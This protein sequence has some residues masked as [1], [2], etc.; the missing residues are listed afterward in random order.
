MFLITLG[1]RGIGDTA[2]LHIREQAD[3]FSRPR[4]SGQVPK[5]IGRWCSQSRARAYST[6]SLVHLAAAG[7]HTWAGLRPSLL[8]PP[9]WIDSFLRHF[10]TRFPFYR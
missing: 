9:R 8:V 4:P 1:E 6:P 7:L 5:V 2:Q 10:R 3:H